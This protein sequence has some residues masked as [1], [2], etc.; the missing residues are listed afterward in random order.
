MMTAKQI[1]EYLGMVIDLE[2]QV[3]TQEQVIKELEQRIN[4]LAIEINYIVPVK[5]KTVKANAIGMAVIAGIGLLMGV[6]NWITKEF[7][8]ALIGFAAFVLLGGNALSELS[9]DLDAE[10][11][12]NEEMAMY[13][14]AV[15]Q[16]RNQV[17]REYPQKLSLQTELRKILDTYQTT[18]E[19]LQK[20]Y[21]YNVLYPKYR[22]YVMVCSMYEYF[23]SGR[24]TTLE[25]HEGAY[26]ILESELRL[27]RIVSKLDD[28]IRNMNEIKRNQWT[29]YDS[30][31]ESN[32]T[33]QRLVASCD[34][35]AN[36][37]SNIQAQGSE[38]NSR[39]ANL[40]L[41]SALT[42]YE[43]DCSR[44][45]LEYLNRMNELR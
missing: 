32:N 4:R 2:K 23:A 33:A 20:L 29:L 10:N 34:N 14:Q 41:T 7:L 12:Y 38:M 1:K 35:M 6:I 22:N 44:R 31:Q 19:T 27:D 39:I 8:W 37:I 24:C 25:G 21:N 16:N 9:D 43:A 30:I 36:Q 42:L 5:P 3:H 17:A 11:K 45:E 28:V 18:S 40:Q 15:A 13:N 26:N